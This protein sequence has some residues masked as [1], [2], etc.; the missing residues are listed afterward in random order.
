MLQMG[1]INADASLMALQMVLEGATDPADR[2]NTNLETVKIVFE[3]VVDEDSILVDSD[4]LESATLILSE[5]Q[6]WGNDN[7]TNLDVLHNSS[8]E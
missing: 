4:G 6:S 5:L 3:T 7:T 1:V 2:S 8:A